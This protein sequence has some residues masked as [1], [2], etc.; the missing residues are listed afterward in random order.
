MEPACLLNDRGAPVTVKVAP[1]VSRNANLDAIR[2]V[3]I[4][5]V[6]AHHYINIPVEH[7][8]W[9]G[10]V[11]LRG[12][13]GVDLFFVL[14]GWLIGG[15]LFRAMRTDGRID[16][17]RF[18]TRRWIRTL[19][20][21]YTVAVLLWVGKQGRL[22]LAD[23]LLFAQN[24]T[25]PTA[26]YVSWSLCIEE[27][28]YLVLP[29]VLLAVARTRRLAVATGV[30]FVVA[31]M[32]L[33]WTAFGPMA[34]GTFEDYLETFYPPTHLRLDG[35]VMGV[36]MAALK[37]Y[38]TRA[39]SVCERYAGVLAAAGGFVLVVFTYNPW[40]YGWHEADRMS[41]F[42][43]VPGFFGISAGAAMLLPAAVRSTTAK[44]TWW[45]GAA[46]WIAEHAYALYLTH[47]T[48]FGIAW[49]WLGTKSMPYF[50]LAIGMLSVA[51]LVAWLLRH[52]VEVPGLRFRSWIE[53]RWR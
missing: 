28:F 26:W 19:P 4:L 41:F 23:M 47:T 12:Y 38:R 15:Q 11:G 35:L 16:L 34:A 45:S 50:I 25:T 37:E 33:R 8:R 7:P 18:W 6:I 24:Y 21:Y 13:V 17:L 52:A 5:L 27:H 43:A 1:A 39:W 3:A 44:P 46:T 31:P 29:V 9:M 2:S 40:A 42:A 51:L 53:A 48:V 14:S 10:I 32:I 36:L 49:R 20:A 30:V 22:P